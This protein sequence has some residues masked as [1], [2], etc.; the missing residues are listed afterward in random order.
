MLTA[1]ALACSVAPA[2]RESLKQSTRRGL[3]C[4][5]Q[6]GPMEVAQLAGEFAEISGY[7]TVMFAI[8]LVVRTPP[9]PPP[10]PICLAG[11]PNG[12]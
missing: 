7:A 12:P 10:L 9:P 1:F 4:R 8:T 2:Q 3:S 11:L 6:A 5:T